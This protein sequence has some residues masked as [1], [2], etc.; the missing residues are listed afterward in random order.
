MAPRF[1]GTACKSARYALQIAQSI[2]HGAINRARSALCMAGTRP[3]SFLPE[4][5]ASRCDLP[6]PSPAAADDESATVS[7]RGKGV[8]FAG[9]PRWRT[10]PAADD[11]NQP[12]LA[13]RVPA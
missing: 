4:H 3:D 2:P 8:A 6:D 11:T 12:F 10:P 1:C 9:K 5:Q 13:R 7:L